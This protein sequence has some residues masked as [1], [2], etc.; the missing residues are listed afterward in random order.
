MVRPRLAMPP[1]PTSAACCIDRTTEGISATTYL[2]MMPH[3]TAVNI[4]VFFGLYRPHHHHLQ[5]LHGS[6]SQ[7]MGYGLRGHPQRPADR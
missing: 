4:G 6:G 5:R 1:S 2:R 7:G 3:T